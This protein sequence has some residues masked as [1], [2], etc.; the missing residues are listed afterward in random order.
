MS[1]VRCSVDAKNGVDRIEPERF[2]NRGGLP[3]AEFGEAG[4]RVGGV[5]L[6][7]HVGG[8]LAVADQEESHGRSSI[9]TSCCQEHP[10]ALADYPVA[11]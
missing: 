4:P 5:E 7:E 10:V 2:G 8:C 11:S 6:A 3:F 9:G 1:W